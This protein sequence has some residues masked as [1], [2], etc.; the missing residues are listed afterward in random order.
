MVYKYFFHIYR[1][2][3]HFAD[4]I[5]TVQ[6]LFIFM[7]SAFLWQQNTTSKYDIPGTPTYDLKRPLQPF[8]VMFLWSLFLIKSIPHSFQREDMAFYDCMPFAS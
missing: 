2:T 3:F 6:K 1:L 8:M 5:F 7:A 4:C